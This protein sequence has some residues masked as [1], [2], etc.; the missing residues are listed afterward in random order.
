MFRRSRAREV[1][2]QLLFQ[3]DQNPTEIDRLEVVRFARNRLTESELV[4]FAL[5]LYDGVWSHR[6]QVDEVISGTAENWR[7]KRIMPVD[8]N[9]LRIGTYELLIGPEKAPVPIVLNEAIELAR[10]YGTADSPGFVNGI[11]DKIAKQRDGTAEPDSDQTSEGNA[12]AG[13]ESSAETAGH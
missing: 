13:S 9:V 8:R 7:L 5:A 10:R 12:E 3:A 6:A 11:L 1:A 4:D 2:L